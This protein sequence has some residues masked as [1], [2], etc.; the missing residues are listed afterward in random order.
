ML[1]K[2]VASQQRHG[3]DTAMHQAVGAPK[4]CMHPALQQTADKRLECFLYNITHTKVL[5]QQSLT[6]LH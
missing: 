3:A 4:L 6:L 2:A 1:T 5:N